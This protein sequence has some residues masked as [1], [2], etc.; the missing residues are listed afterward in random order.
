[1]RVQAS[2]RTVLIVL[3]HHNPPAAL[4]LSMTRGRAIS[5]LKVLHECN[6][7][8][9]I[10]PVVVG[11]F[12]CVRSRVFLLVELLSL[13]VN[14]QWKRMWC[15][16][17]NVLLDAVLDKYGELL[18]HFLFVHVSNIRPRETMQNY[19]SRSYTHKK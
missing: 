8:M 6:S 11:Q 15:D 5:M 17:A 3:G 4:A 10:T 13:R 18:C 12:F 19:Y 16:V 2:S 9:C 7:S 14:Y 1:V